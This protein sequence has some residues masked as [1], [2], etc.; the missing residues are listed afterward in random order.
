MFMKP[1]V[2]MLQFNKDENYKLY[3]NIHDLLSAHPIKC[4]DVYCLGINNQ[5]PATVQL[6]KVE[7][8]FCI[9]K[10]HDAQYTRL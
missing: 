4:T 2:W 1:L 7:T 9:Q 8:I 5:N 6:F 3:R 10:D